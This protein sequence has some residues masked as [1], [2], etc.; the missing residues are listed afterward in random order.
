MVVTKNEKADLEIRTDSMYVINGM[1]SW[2]PR[3]NKSK[4][5]KVSNADLWARL[6]EARE[7]R[8]GKTRF[9]HV[10]GHSG[11]PGNDEADRLAVA[12][13]KLRMRSR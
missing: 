13:A 5:E 1:D 7:T 2:M 3:W 4:W 11:E 10:R 9:V 6:K 12:G 8:A